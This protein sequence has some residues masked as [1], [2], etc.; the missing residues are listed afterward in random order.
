MKTTSIHIPVISF[1]VLAVCFSTVVFSQNKKEQ[2]IINTLPSK[3]PIKIEIINGGMKS[4]LEEIEI[5]VTNI[6][7]RPIY[8]LALNLASADEF[9]PRHRVGI[10]TRLTL[11]NLRLADFSR[12]P[13]Y[14]ASE[15]AN[16]T[17]FEPGETKAFGISKQEAYWFWK[18]MEEKGY[19]SKS[20]LV[21]EHITLSFGD[22]T[23][24]MTPQAVEV[25]ERKEVSPGSIK[26]TRGGFFLHR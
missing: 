4:A 11:G 6:G 14:L 26:P 18:V 17:P 10:S 21:L 12:P 5:R 22:G 20:K 8:Y 23:G 25:T 24:Y 16:T 9:M 2:R 13:D 19:S 1:F 3:L 7:K 15:R